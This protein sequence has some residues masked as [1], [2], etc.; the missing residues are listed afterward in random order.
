MIW[1]TLAGNQVKFGNVLTVTRIIYAQPVSQ[2]N[3]YNFDFSLH[4]N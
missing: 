3:I 2:V 1:P 4:L